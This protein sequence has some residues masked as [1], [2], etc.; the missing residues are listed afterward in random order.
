MNRLHK[1][2]T[3]FIILLLLLPI[4]LTTACRQAPVTQDAAATP[5]TTPLPLQNASATA[6]GPLADGAVRIDNVVG[7]KVE[8]SDS[9]WGQVQ[10]VILLKDTAGAAGTNRVVVLWTLAERITVVPTVPA[11]QAAFV[12]FVQNKNNRCDVGSCVADAV[13]ISLHTLDELH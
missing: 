7:V 10:L 12:H 4:G 9:T 1:S 3:C 13:T 2:F 5:A 6:A 11:D 8:A